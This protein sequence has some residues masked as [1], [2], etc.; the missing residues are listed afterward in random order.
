MF[1]EPPGVVPGSGRDSRMHQRLQQ[2]PSD[3]AGRARWQDQFLLAGNRVAR[4]VQE[5]VT[6]IEA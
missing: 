3:V 1:A 2:T 4:I 5:F 6:S